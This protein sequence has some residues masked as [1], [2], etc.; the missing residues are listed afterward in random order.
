MLFR[1]DAVLLHGL[2]PTLPIFVPC[3]IPARP[4]FSP[5]KLT[6][7]YPGSAF[8]SADAHERKRC[9]DLRHRTGARWSQERPPTA[10]PAFSAR[11]NSGQHTDQRRQTV[12]LSRL[13]HNSMFTD[14]GCFNT[15]HSGPFV[16]AKVRHAVAFINPWIPDH[17]RQ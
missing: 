6:H 14:A 4:S 9:V 11:Q 3:V 7:N 15:N 12:G 10:G 1:S 17:C 8:P 2:K 5:Y 13:Q 16:V